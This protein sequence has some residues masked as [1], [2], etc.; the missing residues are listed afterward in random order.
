MN[1]GTRT[2]RETTGRAADRAARRAFRPSRTVPAVVVAALLAALGLLVA[3]ETI[4]ALF[5][6]PLRLVPYDRILDRAISVTWASPAA[7]LTAAA[8]TLVGLALLLIAL[9]PGRPRLI[10]VRTGDAD[11]V[12]GMR[13][14]GFTRALA[15]AAEDVPGVRAAVASVHG[16]A[17]TVTAVTSGWDE[18]GFGEAVRGAVLDRLAALDP[19]E[20]YQVHVT[21]RERT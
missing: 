18:E 16:H 2:A 8:V 15:H 14:K 12:I 9:V 19:I 6:R 7:L 1:A 5:G 13:P 10:P 11:L 17:V 4:S 21:V 3:A 20:P